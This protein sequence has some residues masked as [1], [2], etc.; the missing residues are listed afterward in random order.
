MNTLQG[1]ACRVP[2]PIE[3]QHRKRGAGDDVGTEELV[4]PGKKARSAHPVETLP[5]VLRLEAFVASRH[6]LRAPG[7]DEIVA[8]HCL[9]PDVR[10]V[11]NVDMDS[12]V[13]TIRVLKNEALGTSGVATCFAVCARGVDINGVTILA[14]KHVS[15]AST[16]REV[17]DE[18]EQGMSK[19]DVSE[20]QIFI[21]GGQV[22]IQQDKDHPDRVV[23]GTLDQG[24]ELIGLAGD[25]VS[26][27]RIGLSETAEADVEIN[28]ERKGTTGRPGA[29]SVV[30]TKSDVYYAR[31]D[32]VDPKLFQVSAADRA[33]ADRAA[34]DSE[35]SDNEASDNEASALPPSV[36]G[37]GS[38]SW[39]G[40]AA[41]EPAPLGNL[42]EGLE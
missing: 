5:D 11:E 16:S 14:M 17:I 6:V 19:Q 1:A 35:A 15:S 27:A 38:A 8:P 40:Y 37:P 25:R 24:M 30:I 23:L 2:V 41:W 18:L 22:S 31:G 4:S 20:Y 34:A 39:G 26:A 21:V 28:C 3:G 12:K 36:D 7:I 13:S 9:P 32:H 10:V 42:F 29:V 33:A